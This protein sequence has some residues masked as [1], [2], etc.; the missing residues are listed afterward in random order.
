MNRK[1]KKETQLGLK[2]GLREFAIN[3][4]DYIVV[5][6]KGNVDVL[7]PNIFN[8]IFEKIK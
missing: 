8:S 6:R 4:N 3:E 2:L 7:N 1:E 5:D